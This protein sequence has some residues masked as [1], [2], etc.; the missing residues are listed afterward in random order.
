MN[1]RNI[2]RL[3]AG[4]ALALATLAVSAHSFKIGAID[5]ADPIARPTAP[6]QP[7]GTAYMKL[8]NKGAADRLI[9]AS[10]TAAQSVEL[11]AMVMDADVM[12]M[13]QIDAI[14][15]PSG[16]LVELKSGGYHL[17]LVGLKAPLKSGDKVPLKLKFEKA[18]EVEVMIKVEPATSADSKAG[19]S[20][21]HAH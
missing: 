17:S 20:H 4:S 19:G 16:Q 9:V 11:H 2:C 5:I 8:T 13:R 18:G 14:E 12:K 7:S 3:I 6:G 1:T 15:L 21:E 10:T